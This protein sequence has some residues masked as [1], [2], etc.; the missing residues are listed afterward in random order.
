MI[1]EILLK[2][3]GK[4]YELNCL[5]GI[6]KSKIKQRSLKTNKE[7]DQKILTEIQNNLFIAQ[8]EIA[9]INGEIQISPIN[10]FLDKLDEA[11]VFLAEAIRGHEVFLPKLEHFII[12]EGSEIGAS[13]F[14]L[15]AFTRNTILEM[16]YFDPEFKC[17]VEYLERLAYFFFLLARYANLMAGFK[18]TKPSYGEKE[19]RIIP[20]LYPLKEKGVETQKIPDD[21]VEFTEQY[22]DLKKAEADRARKGRE[23]KIMEEKKEE[24][25][26]KKRK[27]ELAKELSEPT[28]LIIDWLYFFKNSEALK[29]IVEA[30]KLRGLGVVCFDVIET[31]E[32][33]TEG[34]TQEFSF[35]YDADYKDAYFTA[36]RRPSRGC[37]RC[38]QLR[39]EEDLISG[40]NP[41][42]ILRVSES[43][44]TGEIWENIKKNLR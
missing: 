14:H 22:V 29:K 39:N 26:R 28:K 25:E 10:L 43:I 7:D 36:R 24:L 15:S 8:A 6:V 19:I 42:V 30:V 33:G 34:A 27:K 1:E 16:N 20:S 21:F 44:K 4:V 5:V 37:G 18:E 17:I 35:F 9:R 3:L 12:P 23:R 13:L 31:V 40:V 11:T 41:K 32:I 38:T 2:P